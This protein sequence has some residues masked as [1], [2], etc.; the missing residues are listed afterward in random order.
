MPSFSQSSG[1]RRPTGT[2]AAPAQSFSAGIPTLPF[3][4]ASQSSVPS[5]FAAGRDRCRASRLADQRQRLADHRAA[6]AKANARRGMIRGLG[7]V[8]LMMFVALTIVMAG[9]AMHQDQRQ[10]QQWEQAR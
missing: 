9:Y 1:S 4:N 3:F 2:Q 8:V 10:Q 5:S 7:Q 6:V